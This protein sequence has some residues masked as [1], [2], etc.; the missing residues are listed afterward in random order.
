VPTDDE[1]NFYTRRVDLTDEQEVGER[2]LNARKW[3]AYGGKL[4]SAI[5]LGGTAVGTTL[6]AIG[7]FLLGDSTTVFPIDMIAIPA[8][9]AYLLN[10]TP[11]F[12]I[13]IKEGEVLTQV[14]P[15]DAMVAEVAL[16]ETPP[17]AK[18]TRA[19]GA[20][21]PKKYAKMGFK[22]GWAAYKK[23]PAYKRKVAAKKKK[24]TKRR[25]KK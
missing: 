24:S 4:G 17:P 8:Y 23:T 19:P 7:G 25:S 13:Y 2:I 16:T 5:P 22:K 21:L 3:A 1:G 12:Q 18:R 10:G 11:A 15:T 20:G 6:G 14:M 9:Q